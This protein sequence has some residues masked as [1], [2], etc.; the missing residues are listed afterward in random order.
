MRAIE[1][2]PDVALIDLGLPGID[3]FEVARQIRLHQNG[4]R[5]VLVALTGY[6]ASEHQSRT[7]DA[8]FDLHLVKPVD[9]VALRSLI[10]DHATP[11][12]SAEAPVVEPPTGG[13]R[14]P[15]LG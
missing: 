15:N 1:V 6:G 9:P 10:A 7:R 5:P 8:G 13:A 14:Q 4:R 11:A 12:K 3:G 2:C